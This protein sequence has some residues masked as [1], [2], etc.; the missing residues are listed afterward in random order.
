MNAMLRDGIETLFERQVENL[1]GSAE[2]QALERG[3]AASEEYDALIE[4]V[5]RA[6]QTTPHQKAK[7]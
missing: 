4:N 5:A 3:H 2:F 7:K 1:V 6:P